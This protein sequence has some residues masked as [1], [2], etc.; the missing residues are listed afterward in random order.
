M[1]IAV[2]PI[3]PAALA[4]IDP[5]ARL[6]DLAG[7]TMGTLWRVRI[8]LPAG[9]APDGLQAAI[10]ARLDGLVAQMS[11]WAPESLLRRFGDAPGG[12]WTALPA[13]FATVMAAGLAIA[14]RSEGAFDPAIGRLTDLHGLGPRAMAGA[15]AAAQIEAA[16]RVSGWR[17]LAFDAEAGRLR[18]PGGLWLDLSGIAKGHAADAIAD[19]LAVAQLRHCLV[20]IGGECAG[21][22]MR[23]DGEPWWV[24]LEVPPGLRAR[25]LRL[26]LHQCAVATS[27]DYVRG[28]HTLDPRTGRRVA[29]GVAAVSVIHDR[30]LEA[31]AWASALT[32]L[33]CEA[34]AAVAV[35]EGLAVRI[36][37]RDG[38]MTREWLSPAL[39]AMLAD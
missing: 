1:R 22:G 33:G 18:Q 6:H 10:Q 35:R 3:D 2:P 9:R 13:D 38:A 12:S 11:H 5:H 27:G 23:P 17:R 39:E 26:A 37:A 8:T 4:G 16:R 29:N 36:L 25:P 20:E 31:D 32:V 21:R 15:P 30:A 28:A 24:D 34:G 19:L 14:E 7:E